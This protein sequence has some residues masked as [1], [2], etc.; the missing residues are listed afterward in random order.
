MNV[1]VE[2][3]SHRWR[4]QGA[5]RGAIVLNWTEDSNKGT[6]ITRQ[7]S[8]RCDMSQHDL[9][10]AQDMVDMVAPL[11]TNFCITH[12]VASNARACMCQTMWDVTSNN[13]PGRLFSVSI[14]RLSMM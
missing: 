4:N 1:K 2:S 7:P 12:Y 10:S 5:V 14:R 13:V 3:D 8:R 11:T 9:V 6:T